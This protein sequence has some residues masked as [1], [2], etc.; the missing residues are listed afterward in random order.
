MN[1]RVYILAIVAVAVGL[2]ELIVGGILP[3]IAQ[4]LNVSVS[5]A[6]QLITIYA[7]VYAIAGPVLLSLT[8]KIERKKLY[9]VTLVVFFLGN[10]MTYFSPTF[11]L[12]VIARIITAMSAA[13]IIV[14]SLTITSRIAKPKNRAKSLGLIYMGISSAL[15][16]GVPIGIVITNA[17]GWR[18]VFLGIMILSIIS[19]ILIYT[20]LDEIQPGQ[21][22]TLKGQLKALGN[23]K[24]MGAHFALLF[25]LAGHYVLYAYFTPFWKQ[26][27]I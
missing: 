6:G 8:G 5:T 24:V 23:I 20:F 26:H 25:L 7:L 3:V 27:Y 17:F 10:V 1:F 15:V 11:T 14:L 19:M 12:V 4:D 9:L 21:V 22:L 18:A 16:L 13:L 2:V